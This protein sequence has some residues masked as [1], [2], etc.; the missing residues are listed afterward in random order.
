MTIVTDMKEQQKWATRAGMR[1]SYF[2]ILIMVVT[3]IVLGIAMVVAMRNP[4]ELKTGLPGSMI[5]AAIA[6][7]IVMLAIIA[8]FFLLR[9]LFKQRPKYRLVPDVPL[10][11]FGK[12][13]WLWV[14]YAFGLEVAVG[15]VMGA[16]NVQSSSNG[17]GSVVA[18]M[19]ASQL[20]AQRMVKKG[21]AHIELNQ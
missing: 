7:E 6:L 5:L 13:I 18:C 3:S 14:A 15:I 2:F 10:N 4:E 17:V 8:N 12:E 20:I 16:L 9:G 1:A 19:C 11:G 21:K